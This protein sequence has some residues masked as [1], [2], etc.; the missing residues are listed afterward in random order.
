MVKSDAPG[1]KVK[2]NKDA[3][4][5]YYWEARTDAVKLGYKPINPPA[6]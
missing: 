4:L 6:L 3:T 1:L 2:K 5:R